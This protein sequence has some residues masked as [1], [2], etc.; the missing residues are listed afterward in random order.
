MFPTWRRAARILRM[1]HT[2]GS[3][4]IRTFMADRMSANSLASSRPSQVIEPP[5][6]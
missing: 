6:K 4:N 1:S 5:F 2:S 3:L